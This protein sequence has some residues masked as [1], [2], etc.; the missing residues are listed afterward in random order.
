MKHVHSELIHAWADG[1]RIEV[2]TD[3]GWTELIQPF[4]DE[5]AKYRIKDLY[6]ELKEAAADP[7]K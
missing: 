2:L 4:W 3:Q 1:A 5:A 6:R 7:T